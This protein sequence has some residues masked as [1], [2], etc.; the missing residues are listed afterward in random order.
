MLKPFLALSANVNVSENVRDCPRTFPWVNNKSMAKW[1]KKNEEAGEPG[2]IKVLV[3]Q[4]VEG[5]LGHQAAHPEIPESETTVL[6]NCHHWLCTQPEIKIC[7][8][9]TLI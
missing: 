4:L 5:R 9:C 8:F 2:D 7:L 3:Q 6:I 1:R